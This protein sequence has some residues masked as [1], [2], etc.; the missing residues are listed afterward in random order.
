MEH[1]IELWSNEIFQAIF[2][3]EKEKVMTRLEYTLWS[4]K[5]RSYVTAFPS[6]YLDGPGFSC[7][8]NLQR[9]TYN[10]F[11]IYSYLPTPPLG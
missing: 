4:G 8:S 7:V 10:W 6:P 5:K 2:K 3:D 11:H 9:K 1:L